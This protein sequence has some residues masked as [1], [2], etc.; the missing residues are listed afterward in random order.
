M[1]HDIRLTLRLPD[2]L[3]AALLAR[4]RVD[5]R[6]IN[7]EIVALLRQALFPSVDADAYR[8]SRTTLKNMP[9]YKLPRPMPRMP[10]RQDS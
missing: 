10:R 1:A 4:A 5:D 2:D 3:H 8:S 7:R 6:S 9:E